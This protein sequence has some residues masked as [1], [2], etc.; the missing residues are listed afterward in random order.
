[1]T[2]ENPPEILD[3]LSNRRRG[4]TL[5]AR[6]CS[7]CGPAISLGSFTKTATTTRG[8]PETEIPSVETPSTEKKS[9]TKF[10]KAS[11]IKDTIPARQAIGNRREATNKNMEEISSFANA[12]DLTST[13]LP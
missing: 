3:F 12:S 5:R 2:K 6:R 1:M 11:S 10:F 8:L 7:P 9:D 13:T 4:S